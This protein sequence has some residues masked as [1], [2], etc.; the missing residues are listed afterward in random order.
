MAFGSFKSALVIIL[1]F[2]KFMA[3]SCFRVILLL[4]AFLKR[5]D[6]CNGFSPPGHLHKLLHGILHLPWASYLWSLAKEIPQYRPVASA[7]A[8]KYEKFYSCIFVHL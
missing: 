5:Y 3:G 2:F 7:C 4:C 8:G 6:C 1:F